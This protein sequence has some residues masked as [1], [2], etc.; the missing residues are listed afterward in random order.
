ML[1][2]RYTL[3]K[4]RDS[5][6]TETKTIFIDDKTQRT[7]AFSPDASGKKP[8]LND[9]KDPKDDKY[10]C[11]AYPILPI[12]QPHGAAHILYNDSTQW[13]RETP[14]IESSLL[15]LLLPSIV[16]VDGRDFIGEAKV[17]EAVQGGCVV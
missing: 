3:K 13:P 2:T 12:T 15:F 17:V 7:A 1:D 8:T 9:S 11:R 16:V 5:P 6:V 10:I 14:L 4:T